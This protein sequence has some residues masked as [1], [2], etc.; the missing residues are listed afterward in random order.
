MWPRVLCVSLKTTD[1]YILLIATFGESTESKMSGR[2][3]RWSLIWS[4]PS[5]SCL[6]K[7]KL[8][9]S[10]SLSLSFSLSP[11][12]SFTL[13]FKIGQVIG[14]AACRPADWLQCRYWLARSVQ[15]IS[16]HELVNLCTNTQR[17]RERER[18]T[19]CKPT[20]GIRMIS[21]CW[22]YRHAAAAARS[23]VDIHNEKERK[24]KDRTMNH[25]CMQHDHTCVAMQLAQPKETVGCCCAK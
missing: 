20:A 17:E 15:M 9:L 2:R 4:N 3:N 22:S 18:E 24:S 25:L 23:V 5:R 16:A 13:S 8:I 19:P 1:V 14:H 21:D 7:S 11:S 12:L 10:L 6:L